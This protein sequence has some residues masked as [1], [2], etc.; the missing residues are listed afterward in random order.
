MTM[1]LLVCFN[2]EKPIWWRFGGNPPSSFPLSRDGQWFLVSPALYYSLPT[3]IRSDHF[4]QVLPG[5]MWGPT[6]VIVLGTSD[7]HTI[8]SFQSN[9]MQEALDGIAN[10]LLLNLLHITGQV[11]LP[12]AESLMGV[13]YL[14][15]DALPEPFLTAEVSMGKVQEF[16]WKTAITA[17]CIQAAVE[18]IDVFEPPTYEALYFD[19]AE[20]HRKSDYRKAILYAA[21]AAEI[22]FGW[23]VDLKY[24]RLLVEHN[25]DRHR[26]IR[27][28]L[29]GG[30]E[31]YKD[32]VYE[33]L[34]P[35]ADFKLLINE[36]A[37]YVLNK[38]LLSEN[39][40]LYQ[41]ALRLYATRN[42]LAH[43]GV[44][45][46]E[47]PGKTFSLDH[48]GS[49]NALRTVLD[50]FSWLGV[51]ADF[52]LPEVSFVPVTRLD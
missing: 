3:F 6:H 42:E 40:P 24:D 8:A 32:P 18:S 10:R 23:V 2:Y 28:P 50:L 27:L 34:R 43:S 31:V 1:M 21:M 30:G 52:V 41:R 46:G 38:S 39:E 47:N 44:V 17:D 14:E 19:A 4:T 13:Q 36:V 45:T 33:K 35:R 26:I 7:S 25:D 49:I 29:A 48:V 11:T 16:T 9:K 37:L 20:A 22:V 51:R 5:K 15:I 12:R